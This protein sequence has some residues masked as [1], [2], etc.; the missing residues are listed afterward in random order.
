MLKSSESKNYFLRESF[1]SILLMAKVYANKDE[2]NIIKHDLYLLGMIDPISDGYKI[3][4]RGKDNFKLLYANEESPTLFLVDR[5]ENA[6]NFYNP[7]CENCGKEMEKR[8][9]RL[10]CDDCYEQKKKQ[11]WIKR[12]KKQRNKNVTL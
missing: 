8:R 1:A 2:R 6:L 3:N 11:D 9:K 5:I 4:S 10:I 12:K 7:I